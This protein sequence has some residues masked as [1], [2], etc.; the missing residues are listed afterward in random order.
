MWLH[1]DAA[2][3]GCFAWTAVCVLD[4]AGRAA[5]TNRPLVY[6]AFMDACSEAT[7]CDIAKAARL[8]TE[9]ALSSAAVSAELADAHMRSCVD[10]MRHFEDHLREL[11]LRFRCEIV[12]QNNCPDV[13]IG[14]VQGA[15]HPAS[16]HDGDDAENTYPS[17]SSREA[18]S[19]RATMTCCRNLILWV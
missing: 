17:F 9:R 14:F 1:V 2:Y 5:A 10:L 16:V 11:D 15:V 3:G 18:R 7:A 4:A 6:K 13:L 19:A 8:V 12:D